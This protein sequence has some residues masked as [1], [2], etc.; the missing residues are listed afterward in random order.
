MEPDGSQVQL[1]NLE[2]DHRETKNLAKEQV[3]ITADLMKKLLTWYA[4]VVVKNAV[5]KS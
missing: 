4:Y 5:Q 2:K 1:F 3:K